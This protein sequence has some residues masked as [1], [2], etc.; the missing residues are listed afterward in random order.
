MEIETF[1]A[2]RMSEA[3]FLA[4]CELHHAAFSDRG[5]TLAEVVARKRPVWMGHDVVPGPLVSSGPPVRRAVR[6]GGGR[7][8]GNAG[9]LTRVIGTACGPMTV[10]GLLDVATLPE[11]R[12]RGLGVKLVRAAWSAVDAG[13]YGACLFKTS[14]ARAFYEK[15]GAR[16]IENPLIN[17]AVEGEPRNAP[18][19]RPFGDSFAMIYPANADWPDG[20]ID[21]RGPAF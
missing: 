14:G 10:L 17:S 4:A 6:D 9:T 12:G 20:E 13:E 15:L 19:P 2:G 18:D 21:L 3:E 1:T 7:W 16:V 5:R 8:L 11:T